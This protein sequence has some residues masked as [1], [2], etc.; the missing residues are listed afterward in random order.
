MAQIVAVL[1]YIIQ[2]ATV[3]SS[4]KEGRAA[5][6][7]ATL[8]NLLKEREAKAEQAAS[9]RTFLGERRKANLLRSR[10][11]AAAGASGA[12]VGDKQISDILTGI[13][14]QGEMNALT[15]FHNGELRAQSSFA[16]G[17]AALREGRAAKRK[18]YTSAAFTAL[19]LGRDMG[20]DPNVKTFLSKYG[21]RKR[22][23]DTSTRAY[24]DEWVA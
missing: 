4:I 6:R 18:A 17:Q 9:Q 24:S 13:D 1:P 3:V 8:T 15:A 11:L 10:A 5:A 16:E 7:Q 20:R 2:A 22:F 23:M 14:T 21:G 12:G 19:N